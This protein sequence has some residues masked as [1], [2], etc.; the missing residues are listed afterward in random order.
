LKVKVSYSVNGEAYT[1]EQVFE[2]TATSTEYTYMV[3]AIGSVK[4]KFEVALPDT[5]PANTAKLFLD[6]VRIWAK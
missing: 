1:G 4:I 2:L 3:N 5:P 6:D